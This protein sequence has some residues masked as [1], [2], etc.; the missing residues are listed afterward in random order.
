MKLYFSE[1]IN[2]ILGTPIDRLPTSK[3]YVFSIG[4]EFIFVK[5]LTVSWSLSVARIIFLTRCYACNKVPVEK[6]VL[7]LL[8][9]YEPA[10]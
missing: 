3:S 6:S 1:F 4:M 7:K 5:H 2:L 9:L 8:W 10:I